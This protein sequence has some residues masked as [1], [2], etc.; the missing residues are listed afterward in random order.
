MSMRRIPMSNPGFEYPRE[1]L[2]VTECGYDYRGYGLAWNYG[3]W[4]IDDKEGGSWGRYGGLTEACRG[5]D[6]Y[7][8]K[9]G[10]R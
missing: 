1:Q 4:M 6:E 5:I 7:V 10:G 8:G 3:Y 2:K 9:G